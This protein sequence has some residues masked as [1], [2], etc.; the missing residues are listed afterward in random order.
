M[1]NLCIKSP[2]KEQSN[3]FIHK[4]VF[5]VRQ[6]FIRLTILAS[7]FFFYRVQQIAQS[8]G[9]CTQCTVILTG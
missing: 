9:H 1:T 7:K 4:P 8:T 2:L 3:A 5:T 6:L